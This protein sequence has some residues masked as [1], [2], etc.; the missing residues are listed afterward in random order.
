M[1]TGAQAGRP[2]KTDDFKLDNGKLYQVL[3]EKLPSE[4]VKF[5]RLDTQRL[6]EA[7]GN[8]RYTVYRWLNREALSPRAIKS[9]LRISQSTTDLEKNGAL[10]KK[11]LLPFIGL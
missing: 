6:S 10:T 5:G 4:F 2:R 11:D 3:I 9:L 7:T 8:A 1:E